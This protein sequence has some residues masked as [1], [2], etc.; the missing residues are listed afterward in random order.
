MGCC[1]ENNRLGCIN[2]DKN[3]VNNMKKITEEFIKSGTRPEKF[4]RDYKFENND[5]KL[6]PFHKPIAKVKASN[7]S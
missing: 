3:S 5:K 1:L 6:Q 7:E 4:R 2:R